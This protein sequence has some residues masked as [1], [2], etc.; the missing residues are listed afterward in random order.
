M[1]DDA[2]LARRLRAVRST[3]A[4]RVAAPAAAAAEVEARWHRLRDF[5]RHLGLPA[6][7]RRLPPSLTS[8]TGPCRT[9]STRRSA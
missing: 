5:A 1:E 3:V 2:D 4:P 7:T 6:C 9:S 8:P